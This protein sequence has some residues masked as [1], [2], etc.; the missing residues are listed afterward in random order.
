MSDRVTSL[1][2]FWEAQCCIYL[3]KRQEAPRNPEEKALNVTGTLYN[4]N[5][6][7]HPADFEKPVP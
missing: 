5:G 2:I 7:L 1:P 6:P 3:S 4:T